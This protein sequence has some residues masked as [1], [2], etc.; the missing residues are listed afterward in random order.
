MFKSS[1]DL[2]KDA[3]VALKGMDPKT[4]LAGKDPKALLASYGNLIPKGMDLSKMDSKSMS[5]M[6]NPA[7]LA[8]M[9]G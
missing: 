8:K 9:F 1:A 7:A 6:A 3:L 2:A 5:A 4:F